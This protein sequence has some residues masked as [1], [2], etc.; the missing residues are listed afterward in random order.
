MSQYTSEQIDLMILI[1]K[2]IEVRDRLTR[3]VAEYVQQGRESGMTW[4]QLG[5]ALG[6]STQNAW[7]RYSPRDQQGD[8]VTRPSDL[9]F[10]QFALDLEVE[11]VSD[12]PDKEHLK[13]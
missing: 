1:G 7:E 5:V 9:R 6:C 10:D 11:S 2:T 3:T 12:G 4:A 13:G 8:A